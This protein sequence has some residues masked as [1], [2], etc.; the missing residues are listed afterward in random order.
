L[1]YWFTDLELSEG[2][3]KVFQDEYVMMF[4]PR[5]TRSGSKNISEDSHVLR[6]SVGLNISWRLGGSH[7][8]KHGTPS[9]STRRSLKATASL[10]V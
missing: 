1:V 4:R 2:I 3:A 10:L 6:A 5:R 9:S 7:V 8:T